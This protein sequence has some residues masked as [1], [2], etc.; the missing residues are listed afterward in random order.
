MP[1]LAIPD[2]RFI[3][4]NNSSTIPVTDERAKKVLEHG[5]IH[6]IQQIPYENAI[7]NFLN[8]ICALYLET[9]SFDDE[10]FILINRV[11]RKLT[12]RDFGWNDIKPTED[13]SSYIITVTSEGNQHPLPLQKVSQG[14]LSVLSIIG[15]IFHYLTLRYP[16]VTRSELSKQQAIVVIDEIDAHLHP[17]WQQKIIGILRRNFPIFSSSSQH[18]VRSW[19][20]V[21]LRR[22]F[23]PS[24]TAGGFHHRTIRRKFHRTFGGGDLH[25]SI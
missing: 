24:S 7:Q 8:T 17:G 21:V 6:F 15:L 2:S 18:I 1:V 19:W 10:I 20:Q 9:R 5:A 25:K 13:R 14:T 11:F 16:T 4:K 23:R 22:S 12:H 3:N